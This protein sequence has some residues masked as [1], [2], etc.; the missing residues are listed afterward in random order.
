MAMDLS[1]VF[2][3][4]AK[5][6]SSAK[7]K[8][9]T[10]NPNAESESVRP[11]VQAP[12]TNPFLVPAEQTLTGDSRPVESTAG[13]NKNADGVPQMSSIQELAAYDP[14]SD[15]LVEQ[16]TPQR[17]DLVKAALLNR[18]LAMESAND[19]RNLCDSIDTM[20]EGFGDK[21]AG[22]PLIQVRG[23]VQSLM[24]TLKS[25]PEFDSVL[26]DKDVRNV[27]RFIRAVRGEAL[28]SREI[29]EVKREIKTIKAK[30]K[31]A[32]PSSSLL[33]NAFSQLMLNQSK[34]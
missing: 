21:L 13:S 9:A 15:G 25:H 7:A 19:V 24:V 27:M 5:T 30:A 1:G 10:V 12:E 26:I 28:A 3:K 23:Y 29:K 6:D 20:I 11:Q 4:F 14:S 32:G 17:A 33:E 2:A 16:D 22:P 8:P 34:P 31:S 18:R